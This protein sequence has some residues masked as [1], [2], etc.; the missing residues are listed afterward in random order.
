MKLLAIDIGGSKLMAGIVAENGEVLDSVRTELAPGYDADFLRDTIKT[1]VTSLPYA[2]CSAVGVTVPGL[3]DPDSGM[4]VYAPFSGIEN[5]DISSFLSSLT[6]LPVGIEND[7]NACALAERQFGVCKDVDD[8]VWI[9][10]SNGI[11]GAVFINGALY[12]GASGNAGEIGHVNVCDEDGRRCGC[13]MHGCLEAEA[14]GPAI[15]EEY[16][17]RTGRRLTAKAIA[18]LANDGDTTA[19]EVYKRAGFLIGK[20]LASAVNVLNP[21]LA[22]FGGGLSNDFEL[23][24]PS[25]EGALEL[26]MFKNANKELRVVKTGLGYNAAL[27]GAATLAIK[28]ANDSNNK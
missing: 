27:L 14:A 8:Y 1:A 3:A 4:W 2:Q 20:A 13:G 16:E 9:T 12:R 6:G 25:I 28:K 15:S 7:V 21:G 10:L 18:E 17:L 26:Y 11:G 5:L 23:L 22:V 19:V 24:Q